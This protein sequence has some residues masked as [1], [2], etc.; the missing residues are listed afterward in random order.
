MWTQNSDFTFDFTFKYH[1][2]RSTDREYFEIIKALYRNKIWALI[3]KI[4]SGGKTVI[5]SSYLHN[6]I[7]PASKIAS[8]YRTRSQTHGLTCTALEIRRFLLHVI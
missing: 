2:K 8:M 7:F 4:Q 3:T 5:T 1:D 6:G